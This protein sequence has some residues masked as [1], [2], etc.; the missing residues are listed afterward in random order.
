MIRKP[1]KLRIFVLVM[2]HMNLLFICVR[3][4]YFQ[5]C[6]PMKQCSTRRTRKESIEFLEFTTVRY[7]FLLCFHCSFLFQ[8]RQLNNAS[9][10]S[11]LKTNVNYCFASAMLCSMYDLES[12]FFRICNIQAN[13]P[14]LRHPLKF[15]TY[16]FLDCDKLFPKIKPC[17]T[18]IDF[19]SNLQ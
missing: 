4:P 6:K 16:N 10:Q 3:E 9:K 18:T 17:R 2:F 15:Y 13:C 7:L 19:W 8:L 14:C 12:T 5:S 1:G 11:L